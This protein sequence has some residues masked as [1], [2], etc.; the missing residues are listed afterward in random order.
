MKRFPAVVSLVASAALGVLAVATCLGFA[1]AAF[2]L[3][4][5]VAGFAWLVGLLG[6]CSTDY[7]PRRPYVVGAA[8]RAEP[9]PAPA[10]VR[11]PRRAAAAATAMAPLGLGDEPATVTMS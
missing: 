2:P 4:W 11:A 9:V 6:V 10:A 7:S 8:R 1:P 3:V 5:H